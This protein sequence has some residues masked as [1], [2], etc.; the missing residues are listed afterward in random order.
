MKA[1]LKEQ[2]VEVKLKEG[3]FGPEMDIAAS[4]QANGLAKPILQD[5]DPL[6]KGPIFDPK[7]RGASA[8]LLTTPLDGPLAEKA[9]LLREMKRL[10]LQIVAEAR[11]GVMLAQSNA[12][13]ADTTRVARDLCQEVLAASEGQL[14][15]GRTTSLEVATAQE[16]LRKA[17]F[18][19][20]RAVS[21]YAL[22]L[23]ALRRQMGRFLDEIGGQAKE[24]RFSR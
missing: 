24:P 3:N 1:K 10:E 18:G 5:D 19:E 13:K 11:E 8:V 16:E 15:I 20:I 7:Q 14:K 6:F 22:S 17:Q 4:F 2:G 21:E 9:V 23:S 12:K